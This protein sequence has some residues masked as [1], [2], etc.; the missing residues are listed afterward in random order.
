[1]PLHVMLESL[2]VSDFLNQHL[3]HIV[4][5]L[6]I[7]EGVLLYTFSSITRPEVA[8]AALSIVRPGI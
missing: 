8:N 2:E 4:G 3:E 1:M 6:I 7:D 5:L